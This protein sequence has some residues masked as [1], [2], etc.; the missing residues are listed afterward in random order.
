[1]E[2]FDNN[3]LLGAIEALLFIYGEPLEIRKLAKILGVEEERV[4]SGLKELEE[5]LKNRESGLVLIF[6]GSRVQLAT[7]PDFSRL[8]EDFIKDEYD[9][10]LTPAALETLSL[11]AYLGPI[12]RARIDYFRGVNSS[13]TLR[14][15]LM[16]GLVERI[17]DPKSPHI[18]LYQISFDLLKYLGVSKLEELPDYQ[19]FQSLIS[20]NNAPQQAMPRSEIA[21]DF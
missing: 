19:K 9:E 5:N 12:S 14:N 8:I 6:Q 18:F 13:Y 3:K 2:G 4:K 1:M 16:R 7:K 11:I 15:L 20:E 17:S 21:K 10:T